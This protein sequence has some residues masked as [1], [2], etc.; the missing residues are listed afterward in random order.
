M[1]PQ[2]DD[3]ESGT[4]AR[5][6]THS[7]P[8][9]RARHLLRCGAG[10]LMMKKIDMRAF[11]FPHANML[12]SVYCAACHDRYRDVGLSGGTCCKVGK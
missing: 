10:D 7:D 2:R 9:G 8:T 11:R 6:A 12:L 4:Y 1:I 3:C 5:T